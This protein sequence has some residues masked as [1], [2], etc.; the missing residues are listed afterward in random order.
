M[1]LPRS[2]IN[3]CFSEPSLWGRENCD[4]G[5]RLLLVK[6]SGEQPSLNAA[7]ALQRAAPGRRPARL[8]D[9]T[10]AVRAG[11]WPVPCDDSA[12]AAA[13][14]QRKAETQQMRLT[15]SE[16]SLEE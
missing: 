5:A 16:M 13:C 3:G 6:A 2:R 12:A 10:A 11:G 15:G 7:A 4:A 9:V 1:Y 8:A 14:G